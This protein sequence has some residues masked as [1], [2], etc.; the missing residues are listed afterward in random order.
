MKTITVREATAEER[1][2]GF[3]PIVAGGPR[4]KVPRYVVCNAEQPEDIILVFGMPEG[5]D[6]KSEAV[7]WAERTASKSDLRYEAAPGWEDIVGYF[8]K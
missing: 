5:A 6:S 1:K 8:G 4:C 3:P 7:Y 2:T